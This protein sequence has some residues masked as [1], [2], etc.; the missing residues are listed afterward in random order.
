MRGLWSSQAEGRRRRAGATVAATVLALLIGAAPAAATRLPTVTTGPAT[1]DGNYVNFTGTITSN[2]GCAFVGC[3]AY[4]IIQKQGLPP[5]G[6]IG[7]GTLFWSD[8]STGPQSL[9][10]TVNMTS[11]VNQFPFTTTFTVVLAAEYATGQ[12]VYGA[13]QTFTWPAGRLSVAGVKLLAARAPRVAFRLR[14]GKTQFR[15]ATVT[16]TLRTSGGAL[17]GSFRASAEPG[18]N[19]VQLPKRLARKL[20][21]GVPYRVKLHARD[22]LCRA[23]TGST[24][25][26]LQP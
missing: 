18:Q 25:A 22:N 4:Y 11:V 1:V 24:L 19:L 21:A 10:L 23:A 12:F 5:N 20:T 7:E 8:N 15:S 13:P 17:L 2:N 26:Q 3:P 6:G 9:P 16:I 14:F